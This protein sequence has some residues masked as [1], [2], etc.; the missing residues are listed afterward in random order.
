VEVV[1]TWVY[2]VLGMIAWQVIKM[3]ALAINREVIERRQRRFLKLVSVKFKDDRENVTF[4]ALDTSDKRAMKRLEQ[5][6]RIEFDL[7]EEKR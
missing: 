2:F 7:P 4:I 1:N 6:L 5:Q 3:L